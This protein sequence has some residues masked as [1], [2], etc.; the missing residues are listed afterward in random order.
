M[1]YFFA[2]FFFALS[3]SANGQFTENFTDGD[4]S[5]SP[6]WQGDD[7]VFTIVNVAGNNK[8]RSNKSIPSTTFYLSTAST[9]ATNCQW[10]FWTN[11]E[12]NTSSANYVDI[13]LMAD[14]S[15]LMSAGMN[16]YF[17]RIGGTTDEISLFKRVAGTATKIIDG[18]DGVTNTSNNTLKI[19]VKRTSA[20]DWT[21]ERDIT[22]VGTSYFAEGS[23]NDASVNSSS[24][25]G[26]SITQSTASFI[27]KH[28]F[29]DFYIGPIIYD[30]TPPVL[31]SA[32]VVN[33]TALD[34]LFNE[35]LDPTSASLSSNFSISPTLAITSA[36]VDGSNPAL[37]HLL[38][39]TAISNGSTYTLSTNNIAD[40]A[41][42]ASGSQST[43]FTYLVGEA[44]MKGDVI[45][46]EFVCD[47][48]PVVGLPEVEYVEI[49]NKSTKYFDLTGWKLGDASSDGTL[50]SG[51]LYPGEY[52]ILCS[53]GNIDTFTIQALGVSSFPSLNN[54]GDDIVL[55]DNN[56][57]LLDKITYTDNWYQDP[58]KMEGGYSIELINPNDPCR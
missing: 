27:L 50:L 14:Q 32:S 24:F 16:G 20:N 3:L 47:Q 1:K 53:T 21:L 12:F 39:S 45:I 4:F 43:Q 35:A 26:I 44:P 18:A 23:V 19:K 22:G 48:S 49:F 6:T 28:F 34:V 25:F 29:D 40:I 8:L 11:L 54:A 37:V 41:L 38:L 15:N 57:N 56:G 17:V 55:K 5:T 13:Y 31:L 9:V 7:S 42:N 2:L 58:A 33:S 46:N 10:E 36:T 52:K 51:W 30:V